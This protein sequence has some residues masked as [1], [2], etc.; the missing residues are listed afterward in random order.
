[1]ADTELQFR[2]AFDRESG[3]RI[4]TNEKLKSIQKFALVII[5]WF[6]TAPQR[7]PFDVGVQLGHGLGPA[8]EFKPIWQINYT[9]VFLGK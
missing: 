8:K 7:R 5:T 9:N 3:S 1:M 4:A 6:S 2:G